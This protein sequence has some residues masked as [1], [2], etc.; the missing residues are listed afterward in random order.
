MVIITIVIFTPTTLVVKKVAM[1]PG[2][3]HYSKNYGSISVNITNN[4][5]IFMSGFHKWGTPK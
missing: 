2:I 4:N 3:S 1:I 5:R